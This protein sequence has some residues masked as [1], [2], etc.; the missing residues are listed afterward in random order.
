[1]TVEA[2]EFF[3]NRFHSDVEEEELA[4][5][6]F[7]ILIGV[8]RSKDISAVLQKP[9]LIQKCAVGPGDMHEGFFGKLT[10]FGSFGLGGKRCGQRDGETGCGRDRFREAGSFW[11][12]RG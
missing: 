6:Q 8:H 1:M 3:G 2:S 11:V 9:T 12:V 10:S 5:G 7:E 4:K